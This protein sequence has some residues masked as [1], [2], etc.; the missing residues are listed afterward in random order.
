MD[1]EEQT[2]EQ[3]I[4][5]RVLTGREA[6][7]RSDMRQM[8]LQSLEL[9]GI[10]RYLAQHLT[11]KQQERARALYEAGVDLLFADAMR[12][13]ADARAAVLACKRFDI[14][15]FVTVSV[16]CADI[17]ESKSRALAALICLQEIGA[18]ACGIAAECEIG[19]FCE[20]ISELA[21]Y[22]KVPL[23]ARIQGVDSDSALEL[24]HSGAQIISGFDA[25]RS[26]R[27]CCEKCGISEHFDDGICEGMLVLSNETQSFFLSPDNIEMSEYIQCSQD[28]SDILVELG[29][30]STDIIGV[31]L[32][33]PDDA[34]LF[35]KNVHMAS[36][37][38]IFTIG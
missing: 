21:H 19:D 22:A 38:V 31:E 36:L 35:M 27:L 7:P 9:A 10:Y 34:V 29:D 11:G 14:P 24:I 6:P 5:Q 32:F 28:M 4:W 8:Q 20:I 13:V 16:E 30:T 25:K 3:Q 1:M 23:I 33:S 2:Q 17:T 15:V 26:A 12:S 37:P 18:S